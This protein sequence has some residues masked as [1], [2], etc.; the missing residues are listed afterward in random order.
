MKQKIYLLILSVLTILI[1]S[2]FISAIPELPT[3]VSGEV[4]INEKPAKIGTEIKAELNGNEIVKTKTIEKGKFTILLQNLKEND[5][6]KFYVNNIDSGQSVFYKSGDF[7]QL[8]L[9]VEKSYLTYYA[10][11]G[12]IALAVALIIW[13]IKLKKHH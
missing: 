9:K 3:I 4:Y 11:G 5:S 7:K 2:K 8:T 13:K 1:F 10:I 6:V 12:I